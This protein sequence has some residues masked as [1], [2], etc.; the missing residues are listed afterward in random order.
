VINNQEPTTNIGMRRKRVLN[1]TARKRY[2]R[3]SPGETEASSACPARTRVTQLKSTHQGGVADNGIVKGMLAQ[4]RGANCDS[5]PLLQEVASA[6][7]GHYRMRRTV[8][9]QSGRSGVGMRLER[10]ST[11]SSEDGSVC[12]RIEDSL[13]RHLCGLEKPR[14]QA[15]GCEWQKVGM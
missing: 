7:C 6:R 4:G 1:N 10:R 11:D 8:H 2:D 15:L 9:R 3:K 14:S 5:A 12:G 13:R